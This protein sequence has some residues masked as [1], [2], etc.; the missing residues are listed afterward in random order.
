MACYQPAVFDAIFFK[1]L[2][3]LD[4][5]HHNPQYRPVVAHY[6]DLIWQRNR[7][8]QTG[9]FSFQASGG[10][11]PGVLPQTLEQSAAV[12]IFAVLGW[13]P[14]DYANIV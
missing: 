7:D 5:V 6:A 12:Q 13:E 1:N 3:L 11:A 4:S 10:G 8:P 9:L 2:L 14:N